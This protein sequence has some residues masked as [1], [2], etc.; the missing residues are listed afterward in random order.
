M[1]ERTAGSHGQRRMTL[2]PRALYL[3]TPFRDQSELPLFDTGLPDLN[4]VQLFRTN[5]YVG[6]D[7]VNDANQV[8]FGLTSR[9]FN[10]RQRRA[11]PRGERRP[12]LLLREA[13]RG[14]AGRA[15]GDARHL[16]LH[17]AGFPVG[18]QELE[19]RSGLQWNPEDTRSERS[20]FRLQYRPDGDRVLNLAYRAQ[21]DRLEQADVSGAWPHRQALECL[22]P[23]RLQPARQ[24]D[25]RAV[26]R[27]R[28]QGL[29]L[30][31]P[32]GGATLDLQSRGHAGDQLLRAAGT[33]RTGQCRN[34]PTLSW[35][36]QFED[37]RRK[38]PVR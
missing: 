17:R 24:R 34:T 37:T 20:Q 35:N 13:A 22:R 31:P 25:A 6:A 29:L 3:Y 36:T 19:R 14:A 4:L 11:V 15:G 2:E 32:R 30:A 9:L 33:E 23:V 21:R 8:A 5:R 38:L 7:R 1:F 27:L 26:R 12:G 18:V 16:G 28:I 10:C